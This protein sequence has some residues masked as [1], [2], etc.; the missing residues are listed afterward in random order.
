MRDA[1]NVTVGQTLHC[2]P[3][4]GYRNSSRQELFTQ[5]QKFQ[6]KQKISK[7]FYPGSFS[8]S[9]LI[10]SH[11]DSLFQFRKR[12]VFW[13]QASEDICSRM[14]MNMAWC[15]REVYVAINGTMRELHSV[16]PFNYKQER[17]RVSSVLSIQLAREF[18]T[19]GF[20]E[21]RHDWL[22]DWQLQLLLLYLPPPPKIIPEGGRLMLLSYNVW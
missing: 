21:I 18:V 2:V 1:I 12:A 17:P 16:V 13:G 11:W 6:R 14:Q 15:F 20:S 8:L 4:C 10:S 3:V 9:A 22:T 19:C 7:F 5:G